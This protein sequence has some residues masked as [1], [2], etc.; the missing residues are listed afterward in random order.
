MKNSVNNWAI[1]DASTEQS[2]DTVSAVNRVTG[3]TFSGKY[4]DFNTYV[5]MLDSL[6]SS[7][8]KSAFPILIAASGTIATNGTF[9]SNTAFPETYSGGA[10]CYFP[11]GASLYTAGGSNRPAG[12]Y[13]TVFSSTTVGQ[14]KDLYIPA[15]KPQLLSFSPNMALS[16]VVGS[17]GA[18]TQTTGSDIVLA[19]LKI[20]PTN[21]LEIK[22]LAGVPNN[23]NVKNVKVG[24]VG[25]TALSYDL[26]TSVT[27]RKSV[28][29]INRT[30]SSQVW[31]NGGDINDTSAL[32]KTAVDTSKAFYVHV[33]GNLSASTDYIVL[34]SLEII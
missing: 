5:D 32:F 12:Y 24:I 16:N 20:E 23:A 11:A 30:S 10:W 15:S 8:L 29:F 17:N 26:T 7:S 34:D 19:K 2:P 33:S 13:Y 18:F 6:E 4:Q 25:A 31:A 21:S 1:V 3:E 9:T 28:S 22:V 14:V 27:L